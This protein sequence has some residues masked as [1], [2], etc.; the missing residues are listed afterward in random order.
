MHAPHPHSTAPREAWLERFARSARGFNPGLDDL[1]AHGLAESEYLE[2]GHLE[3]EEAA[4]AYATRE[5]EV[6]TPVPSAGAAIS[7]GL[8]A[9]RKAS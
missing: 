8:A 7:P 9:A 6:R 4:E 3:P 5:V 2:S 1:V